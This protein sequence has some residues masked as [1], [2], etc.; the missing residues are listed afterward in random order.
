MEEEKR[1]TRN[2][3]IMGN[4]KQNSTELRVDKRLNW[5]CQGPRGNSAKVIASK[6]SKAMAVRE[7]SYADVRENTE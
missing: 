4:W 2:K 6:K 3:K 5:D 7:A 1:Q